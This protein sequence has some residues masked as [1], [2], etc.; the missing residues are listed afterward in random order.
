M[1][2]RDVLSLRMICKRTRSLAPSQPSEGGAPKT[3]LALTVEANPPNLRSGLSRARVAT[4]AKCRRYKSPNP[5]FSARKRPCKPFIFNLIQ[6]SAQLIESNRFQ[7]S[8]FHT[9]PHSFPGSPLLT[10]LYDFAPGVYIG[11]PPPRLPSHGN[12]VL[13]RRRFFAGPSTIPHRILREARNA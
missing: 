1:C 8:S 12:G 10:A 3:R 9:H 5:H 6:K 7:A 11:S 4:P 13:H 2:V